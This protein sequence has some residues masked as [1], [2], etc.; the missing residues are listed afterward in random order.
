MSGR[1][2]AERTHNVLIGT[3]QSS[4]ISAVIRSPRERSV[5]RFADSLLVR[6]A[7]MSRSPAITSWS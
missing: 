6:G 1:V 5:R 2:S 7:T 3:G 4:D